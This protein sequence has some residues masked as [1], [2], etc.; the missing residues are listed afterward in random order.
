M[1]SSFKVIKKNLPLYDFR[2]FIA[3]RRVLAIGRIVSG[4]SFCNSLFGVSSSNFSKIAIKFAVFDNLP[5]QPVFSRYQ[6]F[7]FKWIH[8]KQNKRQ[9]LENSPLE[10]LSSSNNSSLVTDTA[11]TIYPRG[12]AIM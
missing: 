7:S 5:S 1:Y 6:L 8:A 9:S 10:I 2:N 3:S 4:F 11:K 12:K